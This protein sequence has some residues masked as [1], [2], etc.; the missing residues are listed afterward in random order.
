MGSL[1]S[2]RHRDRGGRRQG[3]NRTLVA[4][5]DA[6]AKW[7]GQ[8]AVTEDK[9]MGLKLAGVRKAPF[10]GQGLNK[11]VTGLATAPEALEALAACEASGR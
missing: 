4:K 8:A 1:A 11:N 3:P 10:P 2:P 9:A 6:L 5:R 7:L